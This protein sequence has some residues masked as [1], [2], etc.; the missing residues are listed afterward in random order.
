M[1]GTGD[2]RSA[3]TFDDER[4][5]LKACSDFFGGK[6]CLAAI[7]AE[8]WTI[9][10]LTEAVPRGLWP[11]HVLVLK[12]KAVTEVAR[13]VAK[14]MGSDWHDVFSFSNEIVPQLPKLPGSM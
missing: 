5:Y 2:V 8:S 9:E 13:R 1:D 12:S 10:C 3:Y 6:N 4:A 14:A 11:R 7:V